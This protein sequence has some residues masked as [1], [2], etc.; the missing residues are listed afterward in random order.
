MTRIKT[1][2]VAN[3]GEI[4]ARIIDAAHEMGM[5]AVAVYSEPDRLGL[6]VRLAD[7][8][9]A[10]GG[11]TASETYLDA[12]KL[13]DA[14]ER[15]GADAVHPGYGFLSENADFA[16]QVI[17]AGLTWVGPHPD[18]IAR[19][20]DKLAAKRLAAELGIP[21]LASTELEGDA[22]IEWRA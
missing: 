7:V 20:G 17:N 15:T 4:A 9:F 19:M 10:L 2:L 3:R 1:L 18:A 12:H 21:L 11:E 6:P 8:S 22:A 14:A 5:R 16:R 13:L